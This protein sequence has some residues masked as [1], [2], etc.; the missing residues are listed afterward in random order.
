ML[1]GPCQ[2]PGAADRPIFANPLANG[3]NQVNN[4]MPVF[5]KVRKT[6]A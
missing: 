5:Q 6:A 4:L 3:Q 1:H 2:T